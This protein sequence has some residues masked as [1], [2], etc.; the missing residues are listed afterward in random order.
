MNTADKRELL[1]KEILDDADKRAKTI[2]QRAQRDAKKNQQDAEK[3]GAEVTEEALKRAA[4]QAE[5]EAQRTLASVPMEKARTKL[6]VQE[7]MI[8]EMLDAAVQRLAE[9]QG[10]ERIDLAARLLAD[11]ADALGEP[12]LVVEMAEQDH[13]AVG[14][15]IAAAQAILAQRGK[16]PQLRPG[17]NAQN[18]G[19]GVVVR[20]R[21]G[22]KLVDN[23]FQARRERLA[24][25]L[26][27]ELAKLLFEQS[28]DAGGQ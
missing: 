9:L 6:G 19:G 28:E 4:Q 22:H 12:E 27:L 20:T 13:G 1:K 17:P 26:R 7:G 14:D 8:Q 25:Q 21:D 18:I 15:I 10:Q 23:S 3:K 2:I 16:T 11:G 5:R 24:P